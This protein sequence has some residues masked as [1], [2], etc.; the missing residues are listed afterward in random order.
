MPKICRKGKINCLNCDR[1]IHLNIERDFLR[2]KFCSRICSTTYNNHFG[3]LNTKGW[4]P[5]L[6]TKDKMR[7]KKMGLYDGD[8]NPNWKDGKSA[9]RSKYINLREWKRIRVKILKRDNYECQNCN[10]DYKKLDVH[11]II[12]RRIELNNS[13][14]NLITLCGS[15]HISL[16]NQLRG[17]YHS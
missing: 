1:E 14:E 2:K 16:E 3:S 13:S 6:E 4:K 7:L 5:S 8:K 17:D 15:C 11:H 12:P 10:E 9:E